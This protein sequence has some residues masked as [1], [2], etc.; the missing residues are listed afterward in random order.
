MVPQGV[1]CIFGVAL[2]QFV[3][4]LFSY[5]KAAVSALYVVCCHSLKTFSP[6]TQLLPGDRVTDQW[7]C[8]R[9]CDTTLIAPLRTPLRLICA[10]LAPERSKVSS[11]F[12]R[13]FVFVPVRSDS[14]PYA[15]LFEQDP[16]LLR[17]FLGTEHLKTKVA[18]I[19][20]T[21]QIALCFRYIKGSRQCF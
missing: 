16:K 5:S 6:N 13:I 11:S 18:Y 21:L 10:L 20:I 4:V 17:H 3:E 7:F 9:R 2:V 1:D 8:V 12:I 15:S 19:Q 14:V